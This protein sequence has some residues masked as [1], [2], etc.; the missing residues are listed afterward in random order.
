M[1][2]SDLHDE[3]LEIAIKVVIVGNGAVGK[4]SLIQRYCRGVY[5]K[6]Y[7]KTIGVD[8]LEKH[9]R[10]SSEDVRLML[11]D[12]A[13][14][15]EFDAITKA[16]YR[17]AQACVIA[18]S[19]TDRASFEAVK[20]WKKKV[21]DECGGGVNAI[22]MV[23]VQN[24]IDLMHQSAVSAEEVD[25]LAREC[26]MRLY[27]VSVKEDINVGGLFQHLA[28]NYVNKLRSSPPPT[29]S[30]SSSYDSV[31]SGHASGI[32]GG[33]MSLQ[34]QIGGHVRTPPALRT[35][36]G[37]TGS[38]SSGHSS[39]SHFSI[40]PQDYLANPMFDSLNDNRRHRLYWPSSSN[41]SSHDNKTISLKPLVVKRTR[42][43][44]RKLPPLKNGCRVI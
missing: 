34:I 41:S 24:K 12:T 5:T 31:D 28:E 36:I 15:E 26:R 43:L 17:G 27:R 42:N 33:P 38:S 20:K 10:I 4:S 25:H 40:S 2:I 18:F 3:D 14:Q 30:S 29:S 39:I 16:Y 6:G 21:E 37:S 19:T 44:Q 22:P 35:S 8:F 1:Y 9:L 23:L 32:G 13:G 11:W 7:K